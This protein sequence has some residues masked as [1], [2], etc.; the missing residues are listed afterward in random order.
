MLRSVSNR[1]KNMSLRLIAAVVLMSF[2]SACAA[3]PPM[4][5]TPSDVLPT[6]KKIEAGVKDI[7]ISFAKPS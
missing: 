7:S 6:G 5:F 3:M 4:D 1:E 2:L